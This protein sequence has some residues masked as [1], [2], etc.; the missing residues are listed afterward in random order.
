MSK[1]SHCYTNISQETWTSVPCYY[2][3]EPGCYLTVQLLGYHS[4]ED[5]PTPTSH[6]SSD[7]DNEILLIDSR[8]WYYPEDGLQRRRPEVCHVPPWRGHR[9]LRRVLHL[10][11]RVRG[12]VW[13]HR[14]WGNISLSSSEVR[15]YISTCSHQQADLLILLT[16]FLSINE[17]LSHN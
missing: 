6:S 11:E 5:R 13:S 12:E 16:L 10:R 15:Q 1:S 4:E 17:K 3:R 14:T 7:S 2:R 9:Q 8:S